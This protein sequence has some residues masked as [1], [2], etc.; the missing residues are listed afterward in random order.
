MNTT[1]DYS[2]RQVDLCIFPDLQASDTPV[3]AAFGKAPKVVA[4]PL[5]VAQ[6]FARFFMT[7]LGQ[8]PSDPE[9]GSLFAKSLAQGEIRLPSDLTQLFAMEAFRVVEWMLNNSVDAPSDERI[10]QVTLLDYDFTGTAID[11]TIG[12]VTKAGDTVSFR[13]P[14]TWANYS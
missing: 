2:G 7:D 6:N 12:I 1:T 8:Y 11:M 3:D 4:G 14:V 9:A 13:L 5:M 10:S